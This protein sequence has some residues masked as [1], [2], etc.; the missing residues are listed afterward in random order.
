MAAGIKFFCTPPEELEV[1]RYLLS[2]DGVVAFDRRIARPQV[3]PTIDAMAPPSWPTPFA[4]FLWLRSSGPLEWH[5]AKPE[6]GGKTHGD[7]V[8]SLIASMSWDGAP[9]PAGMAMLDTNR[10]PVL[11]Y[12]RG[13]MDGRTIGP[14][15]LT[16]MPSAADRVSP[17]FA[18]WV[19]RCFSWIRRRST[20]VHDWRSQHPSLANP[21]SLLS[22]IYAF[23]KALEAITSGKHD[24][25]ITTH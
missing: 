21:L 14:C 5:S 4:C 16:S 1:L 10:S 19:R 15:D 13:P 11:L 12:R 18:Q 24:F 6:V 20:R 17:V 3:L 8:H 22:S 23:P 25:V 2:S 9:P 7:L